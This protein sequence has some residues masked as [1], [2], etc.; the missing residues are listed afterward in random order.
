MP[1]YISITER[2]LSVRVLKADAI[3]SFM[4]VSITLL[5]GSFS[6]SSSITLISELSSPSENGAS[7]E[8][9]LLEY[10]RALNTSLVPISSW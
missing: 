6:C 2:S 7:N 3:S 9:C 4:E 8:L 5:S 10:C 1:K